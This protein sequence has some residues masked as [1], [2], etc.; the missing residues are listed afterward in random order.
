MKGLLY[1]ILYLVSFYANSALYNINKSY[2]GDTFFRDVNIQKLEE[3]CTKS[4]EY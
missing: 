1:L 4:V 2:Q 3:D